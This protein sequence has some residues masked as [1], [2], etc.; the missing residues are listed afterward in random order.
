M[1]FKMNCEVDFHLKRR[2]VIE[3]KTGRKK[4]IPMD[5]DDLKQAYYWPVKAVFSI[6]KLLEI[7]AAYRKR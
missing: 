1:L 5:N 4:K 6:V 3:K 2:N 7:F